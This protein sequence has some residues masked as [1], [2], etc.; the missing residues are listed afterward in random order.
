MLKASG[1]EVDGPWTYDLIAQD[2]DSIMNRYDIE[3]RLDIVFEQLLRGVSLKKALL[4][5]AGCG[6]GLFSVEAARRGARVVSLDCGPN[7]LRETR[8]K[9][10]T[11]LVAADAARMPISD[12][13]FDIV[14]SSECVEH[15]P[16]PGDTVRELVRVLRPGGWLVV[17]CPNAI[18]RW[19]CSLANALNLRPYQGLENWPSWGEL[20]TW[21]TEAG[22]RVHQHLGL[23]LFPFVIRWTQPILRRLDRLG[24]R[25]GQVYVNQCLAGQKIER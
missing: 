22:I 13:C 18:W 15:T 12:A 23:H 4:L 5:D 6:T 24:S 14:V 7:L 2:F 9:G 17:T 1:P 19:S 21:T 8:R 20:K 3:R 10:I 11:T 25:F 16:S